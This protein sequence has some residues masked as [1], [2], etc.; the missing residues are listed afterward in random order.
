[1]TITESETDR[2]GWFGTMAMLLTGLMIHSAAL[3]D[4]SKA[5]PPSFEAIEQAVR[6][7]SKSQ[8]DLQ[9]GGILSRTDAEAVLDRVEQLGWKIPARG[10][11]LESVLPDSDFLVQQ[12]RSPA[13]TKFT[14]RIGRF[15]QAF[16]RLDRLARLPHGKQTVRDLVRTKGGDQLIEYLTTTPGGAEMGRMLSKT[17]S[18]AEFNKPT[19]RIYTIE[20]LLARLKSQRGE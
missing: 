19:G 10:A 15:P 6:E 8:P 12:L 5:A 4:S 20:M 1:M 17:P 9:S 14:A 2:F 13:G 3:A 16:D 18:G 7:W 11:I